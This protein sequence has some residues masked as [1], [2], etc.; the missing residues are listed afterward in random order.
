MRSVPETR[1]GSRSDTMALSEQMNTLRIGYD[2]SLVPAGGAEMFEKLNAIVTR[3][4]G[5]VVDTVQLSPGAGDLAARAK[6]AWYAKN[7]KWGNGDWIGQG[8]YQGPG[9]WGRRHKPGH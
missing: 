7:D 8:S 3:D 6:A 9:G 2:A 4:G 1:E 5:V